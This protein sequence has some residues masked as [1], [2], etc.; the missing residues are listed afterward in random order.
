M[1]SDEVE[2]SVTAMMGALRPR[3]LAQ[4]RVWDRLDIEAPP[5]EELAETLARQVLVLLRRGDGQRLG[6][7]SPPRAGQVGT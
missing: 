6:G 5:L 2:Q 7:A 4:A 1:A 3:L